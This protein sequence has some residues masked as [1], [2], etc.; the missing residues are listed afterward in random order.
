[1]IVHNIQNNF[2]SGTTLHFDRNKT[3]QMGGNRDVEECGRVRCLHCGRWPC[4]WVREIVEF[5]WN[6]EDF[7]QIVLTGMSTAIR[8]KQLANEAGDEV[9]VGLLIIIWSLFYLLCPF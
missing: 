4:R 2:Q 8:L 3:M 5:L 7:N 6:Q 1:M 9:S